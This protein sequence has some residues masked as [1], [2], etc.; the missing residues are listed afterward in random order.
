MTLMRSS[1]WSSFVDFLIYGMGRAAVLLL[2]A[3]LL[4]IAA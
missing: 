3:A 1:R 2:P 4:L